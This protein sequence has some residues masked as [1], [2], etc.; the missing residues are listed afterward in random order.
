VFVEI[1]F[2][3]GEALGVKKRDSVYIFL[4]RK[5][6]FKVASAQAV[7]RPWNQDGPSL[8]PSHPHACGF[9]PRLRNFATFP[10]LPTSNISEGTSILECTSPFPEVVQ[11]KTSAVRLGYESLSV[12]G[13]SFVH[14]ATWVSH[15][16]Q[17]RLS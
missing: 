6:T 16:I 1:V 9:F 10:F 4:V 17:V 13:M 14:D 8:K 15:D 2:G 7:C 5:C 3:I 11:K 12:P